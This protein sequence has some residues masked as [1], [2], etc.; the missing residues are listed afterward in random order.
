[1]E[2]EPTGVDFEVMIGTQAVPGIILKSRLPQSSLPVYL[3]DQ[4]EYFDR[5]GLYQRDG[6]DYEDNCERFV[7]FCRALFAAMEALDL[8]ADVIHCNDWQ[9]GLIPAYLATEFAEHPRFEQVGSL[10]TIHNLAY[11]GRFWH[12]DM[13]LTGMDWKYFNWKQMEFFGQLNLLKTGIV[14]SDMIS[15]VSPTYAVEMQ[16]SEHGCGLDGILRHRRSDLIG[17]LNGID[18]SWDPATDSLIKA[19]YD[20]SNWQ[21]HK[22]KCK[23]DLQQ[24]L[25]LPVTSQPLIGL[26]GRMAEQKGWSMI[27]EILKLWLEGIE[28]QWAILG[29]GDRE[30]E[31]Q[32]QELAQ[33][34]P[35]RMG[36]RLDFD[37]GLA[38]RIEAGADMF[39][40]PSQYEPCGLN[41]MYSLKY[42]TVPIVHATGGLA[43]TVCHADPDTL[44]DGIA[45][46]F[47][48]VEYS[49]ENLET[50]LARAVQCYLDQPE[51]W[52][53]LVNTGMRQDF[54]WQ[55]SA[56]QYEQLYERLIATRKL[57][58]NQLASSR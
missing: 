5:P 26:V 8:N 13:L 24:E 17:I 29:T 51:V 42:G 50:T 15:T 11:Q 12:W 44:A 33:R 9:T 46:G 1:M 10:M 3:I 40:M 36:L 22:P 49:V 48:F 7:F 27:I 28:V 20:Q 18:E 54:S 47:E 2:I 56:R 6:V 19:R 45:N 57:K 52:Q 16:T 34:F 25:G 58:K 30:Y 35:N 37:N 4:P 31:N 38:H 23:Q 53:Q 43:D 14:F 21:L 55:N 32:L 41:Q 39:L